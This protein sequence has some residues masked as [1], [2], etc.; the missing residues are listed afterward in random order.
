LDESDLLDDSRDYLDMS[1]IDKKTATMSFIPHVGGDK[2]E[3]L[4]TQSKASSK[5]YGA[6]KLSSS[7][8]DKIVSPDTLKKAGSQ[9][10]KKDN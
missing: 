4:S 1:M 5:Y 7:R 6:G 3:N 2:L 9:Q 10:N 8:Y